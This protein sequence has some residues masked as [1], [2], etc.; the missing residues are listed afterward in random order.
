MTSACA[1][2]RSSFAVLLLMAFLPISFAHGKGGVVVG[3]GGHVVRCSGEIDYLSVD[4]V[5]GKKW[6]PNVKPVPARTLSASLNRIASLLE[7]RNPALAK[8]YREFV[9]LFMNGDDSKPYVW[10]TPLSHTT[11]GDDEFDYLPISCRNSRG[12]IDVRQ[13]ILRTATFGPFG[14]PQVVLEFDP[15]VLV[16]LQS[17]GGPIQ[18][19]FVITHEWLWSITD[20]PK[21]NRR[22]NYYMHSPLFERERGKLNVRGVPAR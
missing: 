16:L 20:D 4:Y 1:S 11:P 21:E 7:V 12:S 2:L 19:S 14:D 3:N 10:K 17:Y 5:L 18:L 9:S 22:L 8:S 6:F 15:V 13:A